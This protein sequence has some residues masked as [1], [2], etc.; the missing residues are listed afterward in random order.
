LYPATTDVLAVQLR[1][2][3]CALAVVPVPVS[4]TLAGEFPASLTN[5]A[6]PLAVPV[7]CGVKV[8]D[9]EVD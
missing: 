3:V 5:V 1:P 6:L 8:T 7:V 2:T 4:D 9:T